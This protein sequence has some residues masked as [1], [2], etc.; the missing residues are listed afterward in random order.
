MPPLLVRLSTG[1]MSTLTPGMRAPPGPP[2]AM[3][4][5]RRPPAHRDLRPST[6]SDGTGLLRGHWHSCQ[7]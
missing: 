1:Y 3:V 5:C 4:H 6:H 2:Q 7:C